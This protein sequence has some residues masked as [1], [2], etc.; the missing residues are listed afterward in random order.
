[1]I[2]TSFKFSARTGR[3]PEGTEEPHVGFPSLLT[4]SAPVAV[5]N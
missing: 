4:L 3:D 1:M 5:I 2:G